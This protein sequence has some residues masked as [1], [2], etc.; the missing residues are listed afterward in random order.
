MV[1]E[2]EAIWEDDGGPPGPPPAEPTN[3]RPPVT[4][5]GVIVV[6]ALLPFFLFPVLGLAL[7]RRAGILGL[8]VGGF[9]GFALAMGLGCLVGNRLE[10]P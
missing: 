10:R 2:W 9:L 1:R 5:G 8:V 4:P 6:V 3:E 7:G